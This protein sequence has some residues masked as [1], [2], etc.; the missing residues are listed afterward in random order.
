ML[1]EHI[2]KTI[3]LL[4][5]NHHHRLRFVAKCK[6]PRYQ[7]QLRHPMRIVRLREDF[8]FWWRINFFWYLF[9]P[10]EYYYLKKKKKYLIKKKRYSLEWMHHVFSSSSAI[11][12]STLIAHEAKQSP[13]ENVGEN[14]I[15]ATTS[16]T[17]FPKTL[18]AIAVI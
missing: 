1:Q 16:A 4:S 10:T 7:I 18:L 5:E 2:N 15:H 11:S 9:S 12:T 3:F 6:Y 8:I 14:I 17:A 13:T